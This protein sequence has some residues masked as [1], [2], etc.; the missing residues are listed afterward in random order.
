MHQ[1]GAQYLEEMEIPAWWFFA[2]LKTMLIL[3]KILKAQFTQITDPPPH[4]LVELD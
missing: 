1:R 2:I 4:Y 3:K